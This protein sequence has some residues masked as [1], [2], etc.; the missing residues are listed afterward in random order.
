MDWTLNKTFNIEF[1]LYFELLEG[2]LRTENFANKLNL[3]RV[4]AGV[5]NHNITID[6]D[7]KNCEQWNGEKSIAK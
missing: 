7:C 5:G 2:F 4:Y 1:V 3:P 6:S